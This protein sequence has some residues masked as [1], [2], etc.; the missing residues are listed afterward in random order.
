MSVSQIILQTTHDLLRDSRAPEAAA[1][2]KRCLQPLAIALALAALWFALHQYRGVVHDGRLYAVQALNALHP[3]RFASD[4]YFLYGSQDSFTVFSLLYK[5]LVA[6]LG[7]GSAHRLVTL[8]GEAAFVSSLFFFVRTLFPDR[9]EALFAFVGAIAA[10]SGYGGLASFHYDEIFATPRPFAEALVL[11]AFSL[12]FTG[13]PIFAC[14]TLV[15]AA[16]LHPIM[17]LT[18]MAGLGLLAAMKDRRLLILA[19]AAAALG[20]LLGACSVQPF[21]RLFEAFDP[22]WFDVVRQRCVFAF[23]TRWTVDDYLAIAASLGLAVVCLRW[24]DRMLRSLAFVF[25]IVS[26]AA[27][28]LTF[29]GGDVGRD[30]LVVNVQPWRALWLSRLLGNIVLGVL[31]LRARPDSVSRWPLLVAAILSALTRLG[32]CAPALGEFVTI[33]ALVLFFVENRFERPIPSSIRKLVLALFGVAASSSL[34]FAWVFS[35]K[36]EFSVDCAVVLIGAASF[37]L[38]IALDRGRMSAARATVAAGLAFGAAL[39]LND[40]R[41]DWQR[42]LEQPDVSAGLAEFAGEESNLYWRDSPEILWLKLER[43]SFYSCLQGTGAMFY[44]GTAIDYARRGQ[45]LAKLEASQFR[46]GPEHACYHTSAQQIDGPLS[47]EDIRRACRALPDL[48]GVVLGVALPGASPRAWTSPA[49]RFYVS[50]EKTES[51]ET[52]Y[53]YMCR[54]LR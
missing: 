24:K 31:V 28:A 2:R 20:V 12:T 10:Q 45:A 39:L 41:T 54:D 1:A 38:L 35:A 5:P 19:G 17:A 13:K 4:L 22:E 26:L 53:K 49:T 3:E 48:D 42:F 47:I 37:G 43:S 25:S 30:V 11:T 40:R 33:A 51:V 21:A 36:P 34:F 27:M 7:V 18:G 23:L 32:F 46:H 9:R 6:V 16:A 14:L 50:F 15:L 44:R 8:A 29:V 52:F